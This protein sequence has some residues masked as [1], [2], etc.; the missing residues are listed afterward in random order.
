MRTALRAKKKYGF[1]DGSVKQLA[2]DSLELE[3]WWT[4]NS[5]LVSWVFNTIEPT[6]RSTI[7]HMENIKDMWE[8]IKQR[9]SIGNG[10]RICNL[11]IEL[12]RKREEERVYQFLMGL[13]EEGY[14]TVRSNILSTEPLPNLNR[15]Y[16]MVV[17]QE[18]RNYDTNQGRKRQ[19]YEFCNS[20]SNRPR[21]TSAGRG[22]GQ[23]RGN[24]AGHSKGGVARANAT[25]AT[26]VDGRHGIVTNSD[27]K[28]LSRL[29]EEQWAALLGM[30]NS[31]QNGGNER[32]TGTLAFLSELRDIV[33]C[34]VGLPNGEKTLAVKEGTVLHGGDLKLQR[35]LYVPNLNC[36]LISVSQLLN[37][38]NLVIQLTNKICAM[39]DLNSRNLIGA[40][41]PYANEKTMGDEL[42]KNGVEELGDEVDGL[43]NNLGKEHDE[44][45]SRENEVNPEMEELIHENSE[46]V[47]RGEV[48]EE[49][50]GRGQRAKQPSVR[51]KDYVTNA[52]KTSPSVCSPSQSDSLGT[53]YSIADY[54]GY[55]KFSA[56]HRCFLAAITTGHEPGSYAE[57]VTDER[58]EQYKARLVIL[59]NNKVEGI[60][61]QETFAPTTK[62]VTVRTFLV[63]AATKNW[64]LHQMDVQNAFLHGDLEEE[65][66]MKIPPGFASQSPRKVCKFR[67]S[68]YSLRQAP[69][70][71]FAKLTASLKAYEF[72]QSYSD[73]SLFTF[74]AGT[75]QLNVLIYVDDLI[76]S[77]NDVS[78][79]QKFK[80]YL[81]R[82]FHMKDL[83]K[84][85]FF[86]GIEVARN[87]N[88]IFLCQRKYALDVISEVG[89]LGYKLAKTPLEQNHKL[90]LTESDDVDD[91]AQYR[92]L[93]GRLIYL[94]ITRLE[95]SYCVHILAQFMQ[96]PK[97][98]HWEAAARLKGLLNSL[99]VAHTEP[100]NLYCDSQA[101]LHIAANPVYHER[102]KHIEV[103]YHFIRDEIL[104]GNIRTDYVR[105][106]MQPVDIFIKAL[107]KNQFDFLLRKLGIRDLHAPT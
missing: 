106:S 62:M 12:E 7:S 97:K 104:N 55:D 75:V 103:D 88:G 73:Y 33:P 94:T 46:G 10:P 4:V 49:Q 79:V 25:K 86:L 5:M 45:V 13:D 18:E 93:V 68:L 6:L 50:L 76:I 63:V 24:G 40:E 2:D 72:E 29:N 74:R 53:P 95:L 27:R 78:A 14:R 44:S 89:L 56:Q 81:S 35:V 87:S 34:S 99:G 96:Q 102:Y 21:G 51:L 3:D 66:Y 80:N 71:W 41:F 19:S 70:C 15:A 36:N 48:V 37:D 59:G 82:C 54:V 85:K 67:K 60:D 17:Q 47:D 31:C 20:S 16:A 91:P 52:I 22:G 92:G 84:L 11:T 42:I 64:E 83:G 98:A 101:A 32:L 39:Q 100:M 77:S 28:G 30:L 65:V 43:E 9:F 26:G 105:S 107:G 90:A 58:V 38:S 57:A 8:D 23:K 69:R 1:I 61:Y